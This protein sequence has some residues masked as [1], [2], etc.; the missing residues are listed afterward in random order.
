MFAAVLVLA[1]C[2]PSGETGAAVGPGSQ[3]PTPVTP[4]G[5]EGEFAQ[6][7]EPQTAPQPA[8]DAPEV[9]DELARRVRERLGAE[10]TVHRECE[11]LLGIDCNAAA[12]GPYYYV[13]AQ[14]LE[15]VAKCGG[16]CMMAPCEDCPPD[17]WTCEPAY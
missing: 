3:T 14:D 15:V 9:S 13:R 8:T 1:A 10:C 16:H 2:K 17:A 6:I 7:Q 11:D 4:S 12:D 5:E